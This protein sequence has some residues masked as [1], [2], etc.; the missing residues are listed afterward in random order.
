M[1][2]ENDGTYFFSV[3]CPL[4]LVSSPAGLIELSCGLITVDCD[5]KVD[6][7]VACLLH[8][9]INEKPW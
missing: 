5:V 8:L 4:A 3:I 2:G 9:E 7:S 6:L 1:T